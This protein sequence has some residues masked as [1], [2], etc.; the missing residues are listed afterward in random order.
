MPLHSGALI[1]LA[2]LTPASFAQQVQPDTIPVKNWPVREAST[3]VLSG[4]DAVA[5]SSSSG[6]VYIAISP[7]RVM[8]TRGRGGSGKTGPFGP[9]SLVAGQARVV[10]VPSSN[11]GVPVSAAYSLNF[12]SVTPLG[13]PVAWVAAWQDDMGWPGTVVLNAPQ[14]GIVDN[15]G[16]VAA[17]VDGGIQ[18]MATNNCDLVIDLNGYFVQATTVRGPTGPQGPIGPLG[19]AGKT[20]ATGGIGPQGLI[21]NAG[22]TGAVGAA[23][24]IGPVGNTGSIGS[25]GPRGLV[26]NTGPIGPIGNTGAAGA[27]GATGAIGTIGPVGNTGAIGSIGP[28]GLTGNAGAR[29]GAGAT[30]P[31]GPIGNTGTTGSIGPQGLVGNTGPIGPIGNTGATGG[32]GPQGLIG[33]TGAAGA[34]GATGP[35]GPIGPIGN[36]GATGGIGPQGLIGNTGA[37]GA[38][39]ATGPIGPIGPIGNTGA[40]GSIGPQGLIGNTG[41]AG[42]AGATGP[43]GPI[44]NT[45]AIGSM[46]PQGLIGNTGAAGAAGAT[47]PIGPIGNTGATGPAGAGGI[48]AFSDFFALMPP[49]NSATVA[50]GADVSFPQNGPA[51]L[52]GAISRTGP[53]SFALSAIGTYQVMFQVSV[54][55]PGQLNLTLNSAELAYTVVGRATGT[56]QIVGVSLVTTTVA[57]SVLTVRNPAGNSTALT[58][59]PLAGGTSPVSAHLVITQIK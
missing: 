27:A 20:G 52:G 28:Q 56:D 22:A 1:V 53:S 14:G 54:D 46:G 51:S 39:G 43:I 16:I 34:A 38:A 18:V 19:P 26:G 30:G 25:I 48:I 37:A 59:T 33:N 58:I 35:I 10:P 40:T 31:I 42:A 55:E 8:D 49:N 32:I 44:G 2:A 45:G 13:Q 7:C 24:P 15:A 57:N 17:G 29:G 23:G 50:V 3:Q 11:C 4:Q 21:G 5:T 12:V 41:A 9:P 47:G 6:L 36:A